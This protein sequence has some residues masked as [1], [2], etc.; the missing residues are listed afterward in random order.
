MDKVCTR[1]RMNRL[2]VLERYW[3]LLHK[4]FSQLGKGCLGH[5]KR[6][7]MVIES[8]IPAAE[9][10]YL[11]KQYEGDPGSFLVHS[12]RLGETQFEE[13]VSITSG[14]SC[15]Q[16]NLNQ[17][18]LNASFIGKTYQQ[19]MTLVILTALLLSLCF[20][21]GNERLQSTPLS[22]FFQIYNVIMG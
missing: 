10:V 6:W 4:D 22:S 15:W 19:I 9:F 8:A 3:Y 11:G 7:I 12:R 1:M 17:V 5:H 18:L 20:Q 2:D 14:H 21:P 16:E 13:H